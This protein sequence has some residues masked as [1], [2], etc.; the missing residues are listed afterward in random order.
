MCVWYLLD[1]NP[2]LS[3]C[4]LS[5]SILSLI[6]VVTDGFYQYFF[7][8]SIFGNEKYNVY[9]LTGLFVDEPIIGRYIAYLSLF[10]FALI[11]QNFNQ[12]KKTISISFIFL[13][14]CAVLVFLSGE[15]VPFFNIIFFLLLIIIYLP[16]Y[17]VYR[18]SSIF[19]I[20]V[21]IYTVLQINPIAKKRMIDMTV[22]QISKTKIPFLPYS[23]SHEI[24]YK[25]TLK[26]ISDKPLFGVGTNTY[27]FQCK[28]IEYKIGE[29]CS[30][31]PHNFYLQVLA[32]TGIVGFAFLSIFFSY[33]ISIG[34]KQIFF[35]IKRNKNKIISFDKLLYPMVLLVYWWPIMPHMSL[36]NNWNNVLMMLPL[37]FFM[38][39]FYGSSNNGYSNKL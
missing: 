29:G 3:R 18:F 10:A 39:Y 28:K 20:I 30:S 22:N 8:V 25:E 13:I 19:F 35:V 16:K 21:I 33:L 32:E 24:I 15:R 27:R 34:L 36:Y 9:R 31:H 7:E 12:S 26:M 4:L 5:I 17:K 37:G 11:H 1:K 2:Y 6:F 14:I 38:R 23:T